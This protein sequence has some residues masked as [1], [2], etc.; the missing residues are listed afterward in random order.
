MIGCDID[1]DS[2][3]KTVKVVTPKVNQNPSEPS[4]PDQKNYKKLPQTY[5][6]EGYRLTLTSY[7]SNVG[8]NK[9]S[10]IYLRLTNT[11]SNVVR[12]LPAKLVISAD[13]K[14][15]TKY[16]TDVNLYDQDSRLYS[17]YADED[18]E[19]EAYITLPECI[20]SVSKIH[21]EIPVAT[22]TYLGQTVDMVAFNIDTGA[23]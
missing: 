21:I 12:I 18:E 17:K 6:T 5:E 14:E 11:G 13:G 3:T 23:K 10:K 9:L 16:T 2:T 7:N 20:K 22:D 19:L 8:E 4:D 1:W 15:F